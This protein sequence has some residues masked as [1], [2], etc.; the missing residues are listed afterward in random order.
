MKNLYL[1]I[2]ITSVTTTAQAASLEKLSN[3]SDTY[4]SAIDESVTDLLNDAPIN[5]SDLVTARYG[6][7]LNNEQ[8]KPEQTIKQAIYNQRSSDE[9]SRP[10]QVEVKIVSKAPAGIQKAIASAFAYLDD[11]SEEYKKAIPQI[12]AR[13]Q[14][15]VDNAGAVDIY[16]A[17]DSNSWGMCNTLVVFDGH[18][19]EILLA[20]SCYAE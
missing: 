11:E 19:M 3:M 12:T 6:Y 10:D 4:V 8:E 15:A 5:Q 17:Y 13:V 1:A 18:E 16:I 7:T 14:E 20:G 2:L 9:F